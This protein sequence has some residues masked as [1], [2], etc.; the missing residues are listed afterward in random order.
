MNLGRA[1]L[2]FK[3]LVYTPGSV[4]LDLD[5]TGISPEDIDFRLPDNN[6]PKGAPAFTLD[7]LGPDGNSILGTSS[8][9]QSW[10]GPVHVH[11]LG[12]RHGSGRYSVVASYLGVQAT[13]TFVV[14]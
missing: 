9:E 14:S 1:R 2:T 10:F 6:N 4:A 8:E 13:R 11:V 3:S 12:N 7:V 5:V